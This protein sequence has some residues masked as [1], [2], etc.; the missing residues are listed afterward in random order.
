MPVTVAGLGVFIESATVIKLS[1]K[2]PPTGCARTSRG[3]EMDTKKPTPRNPNTLAGTR[4]RGVAPKTPYEG[5]IGTSNGSCL[6][7]SIQAGRR[8]DER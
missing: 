5:G 8:G 7:R 6:P 3:D 4:L 2:I 1:Q